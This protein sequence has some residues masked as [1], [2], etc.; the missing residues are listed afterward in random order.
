ME[1]LLLLLKDLE[2]GMLAEAMRKSPW[3]FPIVNTLHI[4][5]IALLFGAVS[6]L[7]LRLMG[8]WKT[9]PVPGLSRIVVPVAGT[10]LGLALA[11]GVLLFLTRASRY[12]Q[13]PVFQIKMG[14]IVL[15]LVNLALLHR[16]A[17]W[18]A[19][20]EGTA[21]EGRRVAWAGFLSMLLWLGVLIAGRIIAYW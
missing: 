7:D 16:S 18:K 14:L 3:L 17:A 20:Q 19:A 2:T 9:V 1:D 21:T 11:T 5:G 6:C 8:A 10:G 4:L 15:A 13:N 12:A